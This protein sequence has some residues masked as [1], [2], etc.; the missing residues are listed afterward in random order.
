MVSFES[1]K[2]MMGWCPNATPVMRKSLQPV[3]FVNSSQTPSGKSNVENVQSKNVMF[4][5][6]NSLLTIC[7][8][9]GFS[10]I[11]NVSRN[12]DY[13]I[14]IPIVVATYSFFYFIEIKTFQ[15]SVSIDQNNVQ[16]KSIGLKNITLNCKDI[17]SVTPNKLIKSIKFSSTL[18]AIMLMI[19]ATLLAYSVISKEWQLIITIA[20]LLPWWLLVKHKQDGQYHDLDTQLY[21]EHKN[22]K[23][24]EL[25]PYYSIITD[26]MTASRIQAAI[27]HNMWV[28]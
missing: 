16:L 25:T 24:Y 1:I 15:A 22:I 23:W 19:L 10:L 3:D 28:N 5:A 26:D 2:R 12:L 7:F 17:K 20:P 4:S 13:A 21:V 14:L 9:T 8:L 6:N 18:I 11:L 27:E